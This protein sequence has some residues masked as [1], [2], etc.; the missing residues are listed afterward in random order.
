MYPRSLPD[1]SLSLGNISLSL[2]SIHLSP[3]GIPRSLDWIHLFLPGPIAARYLNLEI[4]V[5]YHVDRCTKTTHDSDPDAR[6]IINLHRE[7]FFYQAYTTKKKSGYVMLKEKILYLERRSPVHGGEF[8]SSQIPC[9][10]SLPLYPLALPAPLHPLPAKRTFIYVH[11][12]D[13]NM[14]A[15]SVGYR[16]LLV[17]G[18]YLSV[19]G[20]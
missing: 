16:Y 12:D 19:S 14:F 10:K 2:A 20:K 15:A 13:I 3:A 9:L 8:P 5:R 1:M 18:R 11:T 17:I 7:P 4:I 6:F